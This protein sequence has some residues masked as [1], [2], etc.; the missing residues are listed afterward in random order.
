[1]CE[2]AIERACIENQIL[3]IYNN[4]TNIL[5]H[6]LSNAPANTHSYSYSKTRKHC[7]NNF[8][9][10]FTRKIIIIIIIVII[11]IVIV[12]VIVIE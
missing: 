1:M 9:Q 3:F 12:I 10:Q 7:D 6:M 4:I 11:V 5:H 2:R 8:Q